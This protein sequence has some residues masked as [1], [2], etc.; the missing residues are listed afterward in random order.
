M[1]LDKSIRLPFFHVLVLAFFTILTKSVLERSFSAI[2]FSSKDLG[3]G[4]E[5]L[6]DFSLFMLIFLI[7]WCIYLFLNYLLQEKRK[8]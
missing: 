2:N 3:I 7:Y 6:L 1:D 4:L 5:L 8:T